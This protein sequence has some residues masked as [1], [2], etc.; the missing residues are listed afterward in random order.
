MRLTP[1]KVMGLKLLNKYSL[2]HALWDKSGVCSTWLLGGPQWDWT[3]RVLWLEQSL[4]PQCRVELAFSPLLLTLPSPSSLIPWGHCSK[5]L[6]T[7]PSLWFYF[8][9]NSSKGEKQDFVVLWNGH[10]TWYKVKKYS[11]GKT[12]RKDILRERKR[13]SGQRLSRGNSWLL[14][15]PKVLGS[16]KCV[17]TADKT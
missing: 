17:E 11:Q 7:G 6:F 3:L 15:A 8:Y 16:N 12:W 9:K 5:D 2:S 14:V 1:P 4:I 10:V 13:Q